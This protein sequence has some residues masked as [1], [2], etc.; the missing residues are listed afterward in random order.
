MTAATNIKAEHAN[1]GATVESRELLSAIKLVLGTARR[2]PMEMLT[3]VLIRQAD[4]GVE[5]ASTDLITATSASVARIESYGSGAVHV[6]AAG[7]LAFAKVAA[8]TAKKVELSFERGS[9]QFSFGGR[10]LRGLAGYGDDYPSL[11]LPLHSTRLSVDRPALFALITDA[12]R[13][14]LDDNTRPHLNGVFLRRVDG[15]LQ[16]VATDGS[17]LVK[18]S[19]PMP[20]NDPAIEVLVPRTAISVWSRLLKSTRSA[21]V[22][23]RQNGT[24]VELRAG[25][26]AV[27]TRMLDAKFPPYE[28][29]LSTGWTNELELPRA[30]LADAAR[31]A[32]ALRIGSQPSVRLSTNGHGSLSV[33]AT[34]ADGLVFDEPLSYSGPAFDV[35]LQA[36][37][38]LDA[39][40]LGRED[41]VTLRVSGE[42]DPVAFVSERATAIVAPTRA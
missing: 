7:L 15:A 8:R 9:M 3:R 21:A 30:V 38:M 33:T 40:A 12:A 24:Q 42:F 14:A 11:P 41:R 18:I 29:L 10:T 28:H 16:A 32:I 26:R 23:L 1:F 31:I 6:H 4:H 25:D 20:G 37:Y 36:K 27:V 39:L 17:R 13:H 5:F 19:H 35:R 22:S 34:N 2:S